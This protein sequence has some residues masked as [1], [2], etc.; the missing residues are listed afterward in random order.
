MGCLLDQKEALC[1]PVKGYMA[2]AHKEEYG[3]QKEY[4]ID[5]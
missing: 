4:K 1:V 2:L 5:P 3:Q